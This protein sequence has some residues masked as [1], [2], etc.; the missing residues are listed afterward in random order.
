MATMTEAE[1]PMAIRVL[2]TIPELPV[3]HGEVTSDP[4]VPEHAA[5]PLPRP[6]PPPS[7]R[8]TRARASFPGV[9]IAALAIVAAALW[10]LVAIREATRPGFEAETTRIAD[11]SADAGAAETTLR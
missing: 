6:A 10:S 2:A 5:A 4:A 11:E 7:P 1:G 3:A 9:S 8:R